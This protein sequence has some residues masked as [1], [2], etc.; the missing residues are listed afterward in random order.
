MA[1]AIGALSGWLTRKGVADFSQNV[2]KPPLT[3]PS[4]VF[5]V[6]WGIL[7]ALMALGAVRVYL[8]PAGPDRSRGLKLYWVQLGFNFLWSIIFFNL[9]SYGFALVWLVIY[10]CIR[11]N[12]QQLN[13][14]MKKA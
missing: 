3:P 12:T 5:P 1:E 10:L 6:V 8:S 9:Q 2:T 11:R 13:A 4:W 7:F 14:K